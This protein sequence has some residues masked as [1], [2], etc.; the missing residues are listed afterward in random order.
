[1]HTITKGILMATIMG[2]NGMGAME[3]ITSMTEGSKEGSSPDQPSG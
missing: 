3:A 1:M 2:H